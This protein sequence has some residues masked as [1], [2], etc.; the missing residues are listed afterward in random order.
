MRM[1]I[2]G[3]GLICFEGQMLPEPSKYFEFACFWKDLPDDIKNWALDLRYS[4]ARWRE[5]PSKSILLGCEEL[6]SRIY[7]T[8]SDLI[9]DLRQRFPENDA[10]AICHDWISS[11]NVMRTSAEA[12]DICRWTMAPLDGEIQ[13]FLGLS[14]RF[15][16]T[17][18]HTLQTGKFKFQYR[19]KTGEL[20]S[21]SEETLPGAETF[22]GLPPH[23]PKFLQHIQAAPQEEQI[24]FIHQ[25]A[26]CYSDPRPKT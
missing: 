5:A 26:D 6:E 19:D 17:H 18:A 16:Q 9:A 11:I 4:W 2:P 1:D 23:F 10:T 13:Y 7:S 8:G 21:S 25:F 20:V 22:L 15:I 3:K 12:N 14:L 24:A